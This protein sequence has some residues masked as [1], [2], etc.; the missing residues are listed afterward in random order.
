MKPHVNQAK[1]K[2]PTKH[3]HG[4]RDGGDVVAGG[5]D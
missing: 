5:G 3:T 1:H 4:V 2:T